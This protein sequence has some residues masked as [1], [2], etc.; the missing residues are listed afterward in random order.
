MPP[1]LTRIP[2]AVCVNFWI[3]QN[4]SLFKAHREGVITRTS[5]YCLSLFSV[6]VI[7]FQFS[8]VLISFP[9]QFQLLHQGS[10]VDRDIQDANQKARKLMLKLISTDAIPKSLFIT[11]IETDFEPIAVG[12]FGRV[13]RGEYKGQ[14][15]ALKLLDKGHRRKVGSS[16]FLSSQL[17]T[18]LARVHSPKTFVGKR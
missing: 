10:P 1:L 2:Y 12:G 3:C 18:C 5:S 15:V 14:K 16:T 4:I 7:S 6:C 8:S 11:D 13:F 9:I 17:L